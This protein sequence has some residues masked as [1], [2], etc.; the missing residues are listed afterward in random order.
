M[1]GEAPDDKLVSRALA[2]STSAWNRLIKRYERRV[3]NYALRMVGNPD[4]AQDMMQE[5]FMGVHRNLPGYRGDGVFAAWLFRIAAFRCTD[6]LRRR[7]FHSSFD[8]ADGDRIS[9]NEPQLEAMATH[10]NEQISRAL[11]ELPVEQRHV[12]ELKFFQHFTFEDIAH[13]LGIS[14]NTAKTRLYA[15]LKK[16]KRHEELRDAM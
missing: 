11:L 13:Q 5:V 12:V 14:P 3:Y 10:A 9:P 4:D 15:A 7:R 16:L 8:E 1:L 6:F 2:G